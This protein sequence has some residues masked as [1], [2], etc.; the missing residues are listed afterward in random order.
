MAEPGPTK[1][2][3][4]L[5]S[6]CADIIDKA[7]HNK[8]QEFTEGRRA[9]PRYDGLFCH[10]VFFL[11]SRGRCEARPYFQSRIGVPF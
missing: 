5:S 10:C 8:G 11:S 3:V 9:C 1:V 2:N 4:Q 6:V 7:M